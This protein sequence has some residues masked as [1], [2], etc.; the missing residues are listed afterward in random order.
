[1]SESEKELIEQQL[2]RPLGK[3]FV[4][5]H[6]GVKDE[7]ITPLARSTSELGK[8]I[9]VATSRLVI[10]KGIAE[11]ITAF[12]SLAAKHPDTVLWL[13]G[14]GPD[15]AQFKQ[16]AAGHPN[17]V[18]KG[19]SDEALAYVAA[20]DVFVHPSYHEGFSLSIVEAAML[21]KPVI[22]CAVGG[23]TEI[24][25]DNRTGLLVPPMD[26]AALEQAMEKLYLDRQLGAGLGRAARQAYEASL[27]FEQLV[28]ERFVPLYES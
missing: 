26:A 10:A 21:G 12:T 7:A 15:E 28:T 2:G 4:V 18:F 27:N 13:V 9:Y 1:V 5:I 22:A 11:L 23:N 19:Y 6:N 16:Q 24:V 25:A 8:Y 14:D 17:I 20:G 3:R